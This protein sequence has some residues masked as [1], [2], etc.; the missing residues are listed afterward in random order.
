[1]NYGADFKM[2]K[3]FYSTLKK[4]GVT[5]YQTTLSQVKENEQIKT[6]NL[7]SDESYHSNNILF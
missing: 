6:K 7:I 3:R 1:M 2:G 5:F 4:L